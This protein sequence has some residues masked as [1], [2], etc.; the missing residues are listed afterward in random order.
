MII[1]NEIPQVYLGEYDINVKTYLT[2]SQIQQIIDNYQVLEKLKSDE[3]RK[4]DYWAARQQHID[5]ALL[6]NV[7]DIPE[8]DL[9]KYTH[10]QFLFSGIIDKVK[11]QVVNYNQLIEAFDYTEAWDKTL[12]KIVDSFANILKVNKYDIKKIT[13]GLKELQD[14]GNTGANE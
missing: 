5:M 9:K 6:L 7:T 12:A 11:E 3:G 4:Y 2:Y 8:E 1:K 13:Q 14:D 10:D